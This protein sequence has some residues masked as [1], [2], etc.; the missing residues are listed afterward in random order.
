[1]FFSCVIVYF[2]LM[3]A[4]HV[5]KCFSLVYFTRECEYSNKCYIS[6]FLHS[7][8]N[9]LYDDCICCNVAL[10]VDALKWHLLFSLFPLY[11]RLILIFV[12]YV[13]IYYTHA[14]MHAGVHLEIQ[15][16]SWH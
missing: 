13:I 7:H 2:T 12:N 8:F 1:M 6:K 5:P 9:I 3:I 11:F 14:C 15:Q 10:V 16:N 4:V